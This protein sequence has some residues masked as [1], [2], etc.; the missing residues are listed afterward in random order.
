MMLQEFPYL[1]A[2][3]VKGWLLL[4]A[5]SMGPGPSATA[6]GSG[7]GVHAAYS[8]G[9]D[10]VVSNGDPIGFVDRSLNASSPAVVRER[11]PSFHRG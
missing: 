8:P 5:L 3:T 11:R 7:C 10:T 2:G 1:Y 9:S 4:L 6:Q